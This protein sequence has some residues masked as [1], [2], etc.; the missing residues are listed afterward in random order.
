MFLVNNCRFISFQI[1]S[2][3]T[4]LMQS[5]GLLRNMPKG[6]AYFVGEISPTGKKELLLQRI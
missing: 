2:F 1:F 5:Y 3:S 4:F 6:N